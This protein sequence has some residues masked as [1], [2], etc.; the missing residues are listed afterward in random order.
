MRHPLECLPNLTISYAAE[1]CPLPL[2]G[3][4]T[5]TYVNCCWGQEIAI[6]IIY[7]MLGREGQ[8]A[9]R[10]PYSLQWMWP[11][12]LAVGI[13]FAPELPWWLVRKGRLREA[14][15]NL[16]RLTSLNRETDLVADET[17]A[18]M[19]HTCALEEKTTSGASYLDCFKGVDLRRTEIVCMVW[20][21]Q[22]LAGNSYSS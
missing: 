10:I 4:R 5:T 19:V 15:H 22:N 12:P 6:G 16:Q 20:A 8:W 2:R 18:M 9:Y 3:Y 13:F 7:A 1:V 17:L 14:K 21:L 11:L